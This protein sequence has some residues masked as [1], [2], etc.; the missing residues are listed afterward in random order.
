MP[1]SITPTRT[2]PVFA[3]KSH[4]HRLVRFAQRYEYFPDQTKREITPGLA[5]EFVNGILRVDDQLRARDQEFLRV[6]GKHHTPDD[7]DTGEF[8]DTDTFLRRRAAETS[9]FHELPVAV[10]SSSAT[11]REIAEA[12]IAGDEERIA[13]IHHE[14]E[15]G[16]QRP[17][18]L[19]TCVAAL[20]KAEA[21]AIAHG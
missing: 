10:P 18:V 4:N 5:Y 12:L 15:H 8:D 1:A 14:E 2:E 9:D 3:C 20:E 19:E 17:D 16:H 21:G 6:H 13:E 11:L 7:L